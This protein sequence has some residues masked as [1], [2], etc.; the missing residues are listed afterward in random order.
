MIKFFYN[1]QRK[2]GYEYI[3]LRV[4]DGNFSGTGAILPV[5]RN[6]ENYKIFMGVIEEYRTIIEH[7]KIEDLFT[8]TSTLEAHFPNHQKVKFGIQ[9]A[10]IDLFAKK[11][12]FDINKLLGGVQ[13]TKNEMCGERFFPEYSGDV[14]HVKYLPTILKESRVTFVLTKYPNNEMDNILSALSTNYE[15]LEVISWKELL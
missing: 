6:G 14:F 15:Y 3:V 10:L 5:R 13:N 2:D 9:A 7:M 11:Y 4:E 8:I 12:N 1:L